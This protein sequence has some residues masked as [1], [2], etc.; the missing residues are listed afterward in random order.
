MTSNMKQPSINSAYVAL[1]F[2]YE[3][4]QESISYIN[5]NAL[6]ILKMSLWDIFFCINSAANTCNKY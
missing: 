5:S 6:K 3:V 2:I 4:R 1:Y